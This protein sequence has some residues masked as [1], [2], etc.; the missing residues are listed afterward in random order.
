MIMWDIIINIKDVCSL[1]VSNCQIISSKQGVSYP[2]VIYT[3]YRYLF[4]ITNNSSS[5]NSPSSFIVV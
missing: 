5:F 2:S 4:R 1:P 3:L